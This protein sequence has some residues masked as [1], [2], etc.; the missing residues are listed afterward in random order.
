VPVSFCFEGIKPGIVNQRK[1]KSW[2]S[3]SIVNEE[4][5]EGEI[6]IIF[7]T[8][9]Y[10]YKINKKQ[11]N[12]DYYTDIITFNY[13]VEAI[14]SGDLFISAD[15]V[16]DNARELQLNYKQELLRV[17]IHGVLHLCGYNDK[18]KAE[19]FLMRKLEDHYIGEYH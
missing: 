5:T 18:S 13:N 19:E 7:C 12:H 2:V 9:E 3:K 17:I 14:I 8:D 1:V 4:K 6:T 16:K 15:R 10:L 11:L